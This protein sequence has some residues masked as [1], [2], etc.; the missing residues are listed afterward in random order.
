MT[1]P[2]KH[3]VPQNLEI[4]SCFP[5]GKMLAS[6]GNDNVLNVWSTINGEKITQT[7]P[8]YSFS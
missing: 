4:N 8:T 3:N 5:D 2:A 6:G 1:L 7:V